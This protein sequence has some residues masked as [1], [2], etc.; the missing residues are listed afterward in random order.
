MVPSRSSISAANAELLCR[1]GMVIIRAGEQTFPLVSYLL[2]LSPGSRVMLQS[3]EIYNNRMYSLN[4]KM[5][6]IDSIQSISKA[7]VLPINNLPQYVHFM[8]RVLAKMKRQRGHFIQRLTIPDNAR[9]A[10]TIVFLAPAPSCKV[11]KLGTIV[12]VSS[13]IAVGSSRAACRN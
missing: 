4:S 9:A 7:A 2:M 8:D 13:P 5:D 12:N 6:Y 10:V 1:N 3:V 11:D